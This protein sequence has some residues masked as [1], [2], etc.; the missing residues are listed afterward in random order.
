MPLADMEPV[1]EGEPVGLVLAEAEL[2]ACAGRSAAGR[3]RD[4]REAARS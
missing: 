3:I 4:W 2:E 1:A